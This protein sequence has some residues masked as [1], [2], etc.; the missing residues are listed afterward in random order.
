MCRLVYH[1][2]NIMV[3]LSKSIMSTI[4]Q[5]DTKTPDRI[6]I[7]NMCHDFQTVLAMAYNGGNQGT[8]LKVYH[9]NKYAFITHKAIF[10]N[11]KM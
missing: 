2:S 7:T 9:K 5:G 6:K 11:T 4:R 10:T 3:R 1:T 8:W